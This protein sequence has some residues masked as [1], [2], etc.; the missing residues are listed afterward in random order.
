MQDKL[1]SREFLRKK[2]RFALD[3]LITWK[4]I[5]HSLPGAVFDCYRQAK[6]TSARKSIQCTEVSFMKLV[7]GSYCLNLHTL[8]CVFLGVIANDRQFIVL[9]LE[10]VDQQDNVAY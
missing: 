6:K 10:G 7:S 9:P 5:N 2:S 4:T 3:C 8:V 1:S